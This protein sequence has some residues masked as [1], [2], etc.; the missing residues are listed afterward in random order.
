MKYF[1]S[2]VLCCIHF[3]IQAQDIV[4][5]VVQANN[6]KEP[7]PF[8]QV[9]V[10]PNQTLHQTDTSGK[11]I[12]TNAT[13]P[14]RIIASYSGFVS[15][16]F[17]I[18]TFNPI[19]I[20]LKS[21][22]Q[23][24]EATVRA[25]RE[26]LGLSTMKTLNT[27]VITQKE[28][29][30]AACCN[31]SE[32]FE[33]NPTV[34][35][36]YTDAVSGAKEIQMLGLSGIYTQMLTENMP[37]MRGLGQTFGLNYI[38]GSWM[39]SIQIAKGVGSVSN[40]FESLTG[41]INVEFKKPEES[42]R[43]HLN[44]YQATTGNT[45]FNGIYNTKVS[46]KWA[47]MFM[48][49]G[50]RMQN[51]L[52]HNDD[53][54]LDMPLVQQLNVYNRWRYNGTKN[55][56]AQLGVKMVL[57]QRNG[58]QNNYTEAHKGTDHIY[59]T[60]IKT[61]RFEAY[62]KTGYVF[63]NREGT[64]IGWQ[65]QVTYHKAVSYF[66][67]KNY[68]GLQKSLYSNLM[69]QSYIGNTKHQYKTGV[70]FMLDNFDENYSEPQTTYQRKVSYM[71][72]GTFFEYTYNECEKWAVVAGIRA[73]YHNTF[74]A[75][76]TP[77]LNAK[78]NFTESLVL[79]VAAGNSFR[80]ANIFTD[81]IGYMASSK[82]LV[83]KEAL[84]PERGWNEGIN[85]T[86]K[87]ETQKRPS[88]IAIDY[89]QTQ[90]T[91]QVIADPFSDASYIQFYNLKGK[92]KS[93]SAQIAYNVALFEFLDLRLAYRLDD[94]SVTYYKLGEI[95]KPLVSRNKGL[96][97]IAY[98]SLNEKW[99]FDFTVQYDGR[100]RLT[101]THSHDQNVVSPNTKSPA[102]AMVIAQ[103]TKVFK[104]FEI[105]IG[106]ENLTN[107]TQHNPIIS[108]RNPFDKSFD[109]TDIWGPIMGIRAYAGFRMDIK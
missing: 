77:R 92:S 18:T 40:G 41:A 22:V 27:E 65:N 13:L 45:E 46:N 74:G 87:F 10:L 89:Y 25:S 29:L 34:T 66:G 80:V 93:K 16:T 20:K 91:N 12:I 98:H 95:Q 17:T 85:L 76:Y 61:Q 32:S 68:D 38:P 55:M 108:A 33:T 36:N 96:I 104:K 72:P 49:H 71:V 39:E 60:E 1:Y 56:E 4:C 2:I 15:D 8:A 83:V 107:Y 23:L 75:F 57:D 69:F 42:G 105:Y 48:L 7:L 67:L 28:I 11:V 59:G 82:T 88:S 26:A 53:G 109:A 9:V 94:V 43:A 44:L 79:R 3:V 81:N 102:Y 101:N 5:T 84:L 86:Y 51:K 63:T 90:F 21:M 73:D 70:S 19:T 103:A 24:P 30:K 6:V 50:N 58:G 99:R 100:K 35:V 47:T 52:D 54:F 37:A 62:S 78:Y 14:I 106:G 31:L 97:N 64:S